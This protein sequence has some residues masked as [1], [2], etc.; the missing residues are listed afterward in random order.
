[1]GRKLNRFY[2]L[3]CLDLSVLQELLL[4]TLQLYIL[5]LA[6]MRQQESL[7]LSACPRT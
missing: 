3:R 1:M 7:L 2:G 4:F 5:K 6:C